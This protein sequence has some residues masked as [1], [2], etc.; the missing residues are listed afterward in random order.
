MPSIEVNAAFTM[1]AKTR[2][3][4]YNSFCYFLLIGWPVS[5]EI[6]MLMSPRKTKTTK[7]IAKQLFEKKKLHLKTTAIFNIILFV[8]GVYNNSRDLYSR[9]HGLSI[10]TSPLRIEHL[11][12]FIRAHV[13]D[14]IFSSQI[15]VYAYFHLME[16]KYPSLKISTSKTHGIQRLHTGYKHAKKQGGLLQDFHSRI[17][18]QFNTKIWHQTS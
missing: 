15:A 12:S 10:E 7:N 8:E 17:P 14:L 4:S 16:T 2:T 13:Q 5:G 11:C 18:S 6:L 1:R 3:T 9:K